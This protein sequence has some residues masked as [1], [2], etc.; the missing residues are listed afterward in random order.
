MTS[1][2][3]NNNSGISKL[4][5]TSLQFTTELNVENSHTLLFQTFV[6]QINIQ[7]SQM[8]FVWYFKKVTC[9][10]TTSLLHP[11]VHKLC[12]QVNTT[13]STMFVNME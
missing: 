8:E 6:I 7:T 4:G 11:K 2:Q 12:R 13:Y 10:Q 9:S 5:V 1:C 3:Y